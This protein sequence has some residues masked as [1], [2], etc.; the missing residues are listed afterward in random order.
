MRVLRAGALMLCLTSTKETSIKDAER[1]NRSA[2]T[3]IHFKNIQPGHNIQQWRKLLGSSSNKA[4]LIKFLVEEWKKP[5]HREKLEGKELYVT[6]EQLCFKITKEQWEEA[7]ELKSSQEE[8]DTR[9]L[10]HALHAAESGYK[11]VIITAEDTYVMVL[12]L[13]M[14]HKIPSHLFQKCGT[15]NRTRFLD[16]TTLSRT[17][18]GSVCDSLIGMHA[19]TGCDTVS[20]FAGRGKMTTL[21][22][23]KMDKTYQDAFHELGRSWEVSP[24]LFEKLQEI[25]CHMYLPSTHTTE[26]N[27][28][29]YELFCARRGEVESSQLPPCEDCLF[30]HALRANYQAAIWRRS[31]QSQPFVAN[32]TDC[33]WMTDEDGKLAVNWMRGSPAPDAVMQLLSCKCVRSCELPKCTCLSNGLKCT[34]MCRLQTCQNKAIEEEPVAQQS[35]S[36]SDV[37]DIEED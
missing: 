24:E 27:K 8:A 17:L 6:C 4:S 32:P 18:G 1:A 20:A 33:G 5:Q 35:D 9:L 15:K 16:I 31:L 25:T 2:G 37:D 19:F 34:D 13:G 30:M 3:G 10:L 23:V 28:L 11:S 26:V 7:P 21:K 12:C 29:R 14:C 22:Q 36:E